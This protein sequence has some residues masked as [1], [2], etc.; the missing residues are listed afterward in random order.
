MVRRTPMAD[1]DAID[2]LATGAAAAPRAATIP[3]ADSTM[4]SD[5][6]LLRWRAMQHEGE[7]VGRWARA[8]MQF[9]VL[10]VERSAINEILREVVARGAVE[11][12]CGFVRAGESSAEASARRCLDRT[13]QM[14]LNSLAA[15]AV[16]CCKTHFLV[17]NTCTE[18]D[19]EVNQLSSKPREPVALIFAQL[20]DF[21]NVADV[22]RI[23][24]L[25]RDAATSSSAAAGGLPSNV[26]EDSK[27]A[28]TASCASSSAG[29]GFGLA[30]SMRRSEELVL[31]E[32]FTNQFELVLRAAQL[33]GVENLVMVPLVDVASS[34]FCAALSVD[35]ISRILHLHF[36]ALFDVLEQD[37][38]LAQ[39]YLCAKQAHSWAVTTFNANLHRLKCGL[40]LHERDA[41]HL[42]IALSRCGKQCQRVGLVV[43]GDEWTLLLSRPGGHWTTPAAAAGPLAQHH[44]LLD[45]LSTSLA[46]LTLSRAV[47]GDLGLSRISDHSDQQRGEVWTEVE[48]PLGFEHF[49]QFG[50][51]HE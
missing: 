5:L 1:C 31:K 39:V 43:P 30:F 9:K 18:G 40:V 12:H 13:M 22:D 7:L 21:G 26:S 32:R 20:M 6:M 19:R 34:P 17:A 37:W 46:P 24:A 41:K 38:G 51:S 29:S 42:A 11:D 49:H 23:V 15:H 10:N 14:S 47:T 8:S 44:A 27:V 2:A 4:T 35:V 16:L 48:Q 28:E 45:T 50:G 25:G 3:Y 36:R 33:Q